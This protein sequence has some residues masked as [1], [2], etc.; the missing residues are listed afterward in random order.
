MILAGGKGTRL[1]SVVPVKPMANVKGKPF[2]EWLLLDLCAKGVKRIIFCTGYKGEVIESYFRDGSRWDVDVVYSHEPIPLGTAGAVCYAL[3][4]LNTDRFLVTNG[5]SYCNVDINKLEDMHVARNARATIWLTWMNDRSRY[6]SVVIDKEGEVEILLEKSLDGSGG[7]VNA[8]VYL[9]E[10]GVA[11]T[12][13]ERKHVSLET[14]F[15]PQLIGKG[16]YAVVSNSPL[17]DIG[18]PEAYDRVFRCGVL[19]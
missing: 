14:E 18:T 5:D 7:L 17:L 1:Q 13:S 19:I 11:E 2:V 8:G 15:F 4:K 12:I 6:G 9:L 16:L 3:D 10:R